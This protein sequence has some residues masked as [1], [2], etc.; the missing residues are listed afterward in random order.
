MTGPYAVVRSIT[1][2]YAACPVCCTRPIRRPLGPAGHYSVLWQA[3]ILSCESHRGRRHGTPDRE[4]AD[5]P[6]MREG[7]AKNASATESHNARFPWSW[8]AQNRPESLA[9]WGVCLLWSPLR[10]IGL[11]APFFVSSFPSLRFLARFALSAPPAKAVA[12]PRL[13]RAHADSC[14]YSLGFEACLPGSS[15]AMA[16]GRNS[17]PVAVLGTRDMC[18]Y[19]LVSGHE[20]VDE[21]C[22]QCTSVRA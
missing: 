7:T 8:S 16:R 17:F 10:P 15:D 11:A 12:G 22:G 19:C 13:L 18:L 5:S 14:R 6:S 9:W 3:R 20:V 2:Y 21:A 1:Q 4:R